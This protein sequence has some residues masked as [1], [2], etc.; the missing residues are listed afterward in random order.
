MNKYQLDE[1]IVYKGQ[2]GIVYDYS[3]RNQTYQLKLKKN[4]EYIYSVAE[5]DIKP[6]YSTALIEAADKF[7]DGLSTFTKKYTTTYAAGANEL[8]FLGSIVVDIY[9]ARLLEDPD[10][11][12]LLN[13]KL[14]EAEEK[15]RIVNT[16]N[17]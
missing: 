14:R 4:G 8:R 6:P 2:E 16:R 3:P 5:K 10:F 11:I 17:K 7:V 1:P 15:G 12:T 9:E 13:N